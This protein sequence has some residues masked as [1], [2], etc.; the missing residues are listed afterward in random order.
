MRACRN[1]DPQN[2]TLCFPLTD[3]I[4]VE[5]Q[6]AED[7]GPFLIY[8]LGQV[9]DGVG[10]DD[11]RQFYG[12][13]ICLKIDIRFVLDEPQSKMYRARVSSENELIITVPAWDYNHLHERDLFAGEPKAEQILVDA[14]DNAIDE[15]AQNTPARAVR[16]YKLVF[17][18]DHRLSSKTIFANATEDEWLEA[19]VLP[20]E[21]T[22]AASTLTGKDWYTIWKVVDRSK[23]SR[24]KGKPTESG[25]VSDIA[26]QLQSLG[27]G[28]GATTPM[29]TN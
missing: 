24:K 22:H 27:I 5:T 13:A 16:N 23:G 14:I 26:K 7:N 15:Y 3:T 8:D 1:F 25:N 19:V 17:P 11:S 10:N 28:T 18:V 29:N 21:W 20:I 6:Q 9:V 12:Y 4:Q 2:L